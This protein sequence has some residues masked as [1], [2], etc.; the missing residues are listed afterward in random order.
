MKNQFSLDIKKPCSENFNKFRP[1]E[2]GGFCESCKKEVIDFTSMET[3]EII[4]FFR[5]KDNHD[6]CGRFSNNQLKINAKTIKQNKTLSFISSFGLAFLALFSFNKSYSQ[7]L[8]K[9]I[10]N[11]SQGSQNI[12]SLS[13][14]NDIEVKGTVLDEN[15]LPL[16]GTNVIVEGTTNGTQTNFD[17][18]FKFPERLKIGD[19]LIFSFLGYDSKKVVISSENSTKRI[20][21]AVNMDAI[22]CIVMG[23]VATKG[24]FKSKKK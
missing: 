10:E 2:M 23:K 22:E 6:T 15:G 19:V 16:P 11:S 17:G 7:E 13:Y 3:Q 21:M 18:E 8:Q 14:N 5:K 1:T 20:E 9:Q 12:N 24:V 4:T